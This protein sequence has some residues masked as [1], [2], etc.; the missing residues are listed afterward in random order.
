MRTLRL[1]EQFQL[2]K[3]VPVSIIRLCPISFLLLLLLPL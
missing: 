2:C 3:N 1:R